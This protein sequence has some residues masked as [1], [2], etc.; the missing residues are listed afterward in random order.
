MKPPDK[1]VF[2]QLKQVMLSLASGFEALLSIFLS[3]LAKRKSNKGT[4]PVR[5]KSRQPHTRTHRSDSFF[6]GFS[7][8]RK[9]YNLDIME[10]PKLFREFSKESSQAAL[11]Q[12]RFE[13]LAKQII[14]DYFAE[15]EKK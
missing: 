12:D 8:S 7:F 14:D 9:W 2:A 15:Q 13:A 6:T 10:K 3:F 4:D 1:A 5:V 11:G